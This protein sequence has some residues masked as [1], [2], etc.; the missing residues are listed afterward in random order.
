MTTINF[1]LSGLNTTLAMD[2]SGALTG[3]APTAIDVSATA[4]LYVKTSDMRNVFKFQTDSFDV[5][6]VESA[7]VKYYVHRNVEAWPANLKI[8]PAHAFVTADHMLSAGVDNV[9]NLVKHDFVRYLAKSLFNTVHG[10]DLFSNE[11]ELLTNLAEKGAV[12]RAAIEASLDAVCTT[13]ATLSDTD[14]SNNKYT[15]NSLTDNT[16]LCRQLMLQIANSAA[17]RFQSIENSKFSQSVPLFDGDTFNFKVTISADANQHILTDVA[18]FDSRV[19]GIKLILSSDTA[20]NWSG[21]AML[22]K[23]PVEAAPS[24]AGEYPYAV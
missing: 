14:T 23:V 19:Y 16:N 4:V 15:T 7:D 20:A 22:N 18:A 6:N 2:V 10:V 24:P 1:N 11:T 13:S 8:N 9:K 3:L 17:G 12:A 21:E 5:N